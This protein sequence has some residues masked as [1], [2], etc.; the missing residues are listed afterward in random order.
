MKCVAEAKAG[1]DGLY[2]S[3]CGSQNM[4]ATVLVIPQYRAYDTNLVRDLDCSTRT[5]D[6][7]SLSVSFRCAHS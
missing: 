5:V 7:D 6:E 2:L 1:L 4:V 3:S